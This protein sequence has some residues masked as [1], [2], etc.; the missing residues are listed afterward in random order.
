ME[1]IFHTT[2]P[3]PDGAKLPMVLVFLSLVLSLV[4]A[5]VFAQMRPRGIA[6]AERQSVECVVDIHG[7]AQPVD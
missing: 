1:S 4:I 2:R 6:F 5:I 7:N 3:R